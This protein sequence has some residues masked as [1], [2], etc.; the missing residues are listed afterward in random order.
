MPTE[1][2][3]WGALRILLVLAALPQIAL[4]VQTDVSANSR[5]YMELRF[6]D[7]SVEGIWMTGTSTTQVFFPGANGTAI[8]NNG[9]GRD[10]VST[11]LTILDLAGISPKLGPLH[12]QLTAMPSYG[13]MEEQTNN[14]PGIL[15]VPPY[16]ATGTVDSFF[17][18]FVEIQTPDI[19]LHN[20]VARL[21]AGTINHV[22][23]G[24]GG[25]YQSLASTPLLDPTGAPTGLSIE[26]TRYW[27]NPPVE[28]DT[29]MYSTCQLQLLTPTTTQ[30]IDMSGHSEMRVFFDGVV[31]GSAMDDDDDGRDEVQTEL[32]DWTFVGSNPVLGHVR[33]R[34]YAGAPSFGQM[35][36]QANNTPGILDVPPFAATGH[37]DSF[38]DVFFE[39]EVDG[40]VLHCGTPMRLEGTNAHKPPLLG[41]LLLSQGQVPLHDTSGGSTRYYAKAVSYT[42]NSPAPVCGDA[43]HPHPIGDL[44]LDCRINFLDVAVI[45]AHWLECTAPECEQL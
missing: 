1:K 14:T 38:F 45:A 4:A 43:A 12:L 28:I 36:E 3:K 7:S 35:E 31:Q 11:Q 9:N 37:I 33:L 29:L 19:V 27:P 24:P 21:M 17:D 32:T 13:L 41:E 26:T 30:T 34:L 16:T 23:A 2:P 22:P 20:T 39:V 42:A 18:V 40:Q 15:D 10:D 44:W 6:P 25:M 8:D 5:F